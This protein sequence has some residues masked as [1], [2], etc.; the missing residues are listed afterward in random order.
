MGCGLVST[1]RSKQDPASAP[2]PIFFVLI[3]RFLTLL[4]LPLV[5]CNQSKEDK[6]GQARNAEI[7]AQLKR[8]RLAQRNEIS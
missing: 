5:L 7:E 6:E 4:F 1:E 2:L 8:D 3:L